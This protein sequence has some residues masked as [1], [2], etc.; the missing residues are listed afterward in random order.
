M[1]MMLIMMASIDVIRENLA[2][3]LAA[4]ACFLAVSACPLEESAMDLIELSSSCRCFSAI[5]K[6]FDAL[7]TVVSVQGIKVTEITD[8]HTGRKWK[9]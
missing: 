5:R 3:F 6:I 7:N 1:V 9:L 2:S 4:S 8:K